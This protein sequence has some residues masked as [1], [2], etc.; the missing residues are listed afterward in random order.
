MTEQNQ[1]IIGDALDLYKGNPITL[2]QLACVAEFTE[3]DKKYLGIFSQEWIYL[4]YEM[5]RKWF[6]VGGDKSKVR[7]LYRF[8]LTKHFDEGVDWKT[9]D[10]FG[11]WV[12][13]KVTHETEHGFEVRQNTGGGTK[14]YAV[15][16]SCFSAICDKYEKPEKKASLEKVDL[17]VELLATYVE[18]SC[19]VDT[20][21][22]AI[23]RKVSC[24]LETK[25]MLEKFSYAEITYDQMG[26]AIGMTE[27]QVEML[28]MF[29][30][31]A[32]NKGWIYLSDDIIKSQMTNEKGEASLRNFYKR[33]LLQG[34]YEENVDYKKI[35]AN[36]EL[37]Q[38]WESFC[39]SN[40]GSGKK[41]K[42]SK[43]LLIS[44]YKKP[45]TLPFKFERQK[46]TRGGHNKAYYA[47]TGETYK[48]LLARAST[49]KGR[50]TRDY[51]RK[52]ETLARMM[53][54]YISAL[55]QYLMVKRENELKKQ[56]VAS[57]EL[58]KQKNRKQKLLDAFANHLQGCEPNG[59]LYI[60]TS[61]N[62]SSENYFKVGI[63]TDLKSRLRQYNTERP[64]TDMMYYVFAHECYEPKQI[65]N[66]LKFLLKAFNKKNPKK[67]QKDETYFLGFV[68]LEKIVKLVCEHHDEEVSVLND[69]ISTFA[70]NFLEDSVIPEPINIGEPEPE[71]RIVEITETVNDSAGTMVVHRETIDV[72]TL[73][74]DQKKVKLIQAIEKFAREKK[75]IDDFNYETSKD[76]EDQKMVLIWTDIIQNLMVLCA[77]SNK[78]KI[79]ASKWKDPMKTLVSEAQ[80]LQGVKWK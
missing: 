30:D 29:W 73:T 4:S 67:S 43:C 34:D 75:N 16:H 52:V 26:E 25:Q 49:K 2:E 11:D 65:E 31:P 48:D 7:G 37:V 39:R 47:V 44:T 70:D 76:S 68:K 45:Q 51:Y 63:T 74:V 40:L 55:H 50:K 10:V 46:E 71:T 14:Y 77:I 64:P 53:R 79:M 69:I 6:V 35:K 58:V 38:K 80:C 19:K 28:K 60:A 59:W 23:M 56:L 15:S 13:E 66:K 61:A 3:E 22:M 21:D 41:S 24:E 9:V 57:S 54:D 20:S 17:L 18:E 42:K 5:T 32:F 12:A 33:V 62:Y 1:K 27:E 8:Y 78:R 36:D 72:T